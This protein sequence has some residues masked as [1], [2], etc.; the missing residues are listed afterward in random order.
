MTCLE[1]D[2]VWK[3]AA[4][5]AGRHW[6]D[7]EASGGAFC[8]THIR[9]DAFSR[10][11]DV[12]IVRGGMGMIANSLADSAREQGVQIRTGTIVERIVMDSDGARGVVLD[13][14][15]EISSKLVVS[16]AGL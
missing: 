5:L 11:E 8:Y 16:G 13:D 14:G 1:G 12:G 3:A 10:P 6:G 7:P 15:T 2:D 4:E 9:C